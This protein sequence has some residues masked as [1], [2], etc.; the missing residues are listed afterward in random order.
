MCPVL[1]AFPSRSARAAA[2]ASAAQ[3]DYVLDMGEP[4]G[5]WISQEISS[6]LGVRPDDVPITLSG[7]D[8][9]RNLDEE[10]V[11]RR[12]RR[13]VASRERMQVRPRPTPG[14]A[15]C[16]IRSEPEKAANFEDQPRSWHGSRRIVPDSARRP[17]ID[18]EISRLRLLQPSP[19]HS[20]RSAAAHRVVS[21]PACGH[22][23]RA[24][25]SFQ[26]ERSAGAHTPAVHRQAPLS[27]DACGWRG[28]IDAVG[29]LTHHRRRPASFPISMRLTGLSR[30]AHLLRHPRQRCR[31]S[32]RGS[33]A[34][35]HWPKRGR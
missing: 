21:A 10:L 27:L 1:H 9:A 20:E 34:E 16:G 19:C 14:A 3:F 25:P 6:S 7:C 17:A 5:Y 30:L 4:S 22:A 15:C 8:P 2:A 26:D 11:R 24:P 31:N 18:T 35:Q 33:Q 13:A 29:C 12:S 23:R 28:W 32:R